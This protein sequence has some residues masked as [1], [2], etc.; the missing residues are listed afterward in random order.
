[1]VAAR[2]TRVRGSATSDPQYSL[3]I[4]PTR[5]VKNAL[6]LPLKSELTRM[7]VK[8]WNPGIAPPTA[9]TVPATT[10]WII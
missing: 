1:M 6:A 5:R 2:R 3:A 7:V 9:P 4:I 10:G 8:T